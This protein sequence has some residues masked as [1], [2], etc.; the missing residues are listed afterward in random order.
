MLPYKLNTPMFWS[1]ADQK[2]LEGSWII[3]RSLADKQ[4]ITDDFNSIFPLFF[5]VHF[6]TF[7]SHELEI[8]KRI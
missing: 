6:Y 3:D 7:F 5:Q 4:G 1:S 2:L 8:S